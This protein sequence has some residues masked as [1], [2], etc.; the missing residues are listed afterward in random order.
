MSG[1]QTAAEHIAQTS[2]ASKLP[3]NDVYQQPPTDQ[4]LKA[5]ASAEANSGNGSV[6]P[7]GDLFSSIGSIFSPSAGSVS[8]GNRIYF[9]G[10]PIVLRGA[11]Y[12]KKF[13]KT[14]SVIQALPRQKFLYYTCFNPNPATGIK[15]M[16]T[17]QSGFAFQSQ[18][19][20][21][22]S[23]T[24]TIKKLHQYNRK[25]LV[26]TG[27]DYP[28]VSV[29]FHD[30]VDD[31]VLR[32][33]QQYYQWYFGDG[34]GAIGGSGISTKSSRET[35]WKSSVVERDFSISNG[36]GFS[37]PEST[38]NT[39]FF[40]SMDVYTFYG[41][42]FTQVRMYNPKIVTM[43]WEGLDSETSTFLTCSM[44]I[45][46]EGFEYL[47]IGQRIGESQVTQFGLNQGDYFEPSD[48]FGGL[49]SELL[50]VQDQL[51]GGI[52]NLLG[53]ISSIPF[54]GGA[55]ASA[56]GQ[57]IKSTGITGI[58]PKISSNLASSG[59]AKFGKFF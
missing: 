34:R 52:D 58:I 36:W 57:L 35:A 4:Q 16:G 19:V 54:V 48:L 18:K 49:N 59:L 8:G 9:N 30:T 42:Y 50:A 11:Q 32:V 24:A 39:N 1:S 22:P 10:N 37:P 29:T 26:Q 28:D 55:L 43:D 2:Y 14:A 53:N 6:S 23:A 15:D 17:W 3:Y 25:R 33:W 38:N 7:V 47:N 40:D 5:A 46:H 13:T 45:E 56:G 21:R 12:A 31:R 20:D 44:K 41:K 51:Q 27:I